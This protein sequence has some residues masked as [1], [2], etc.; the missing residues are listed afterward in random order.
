MLRISASRTAS[1]AVTVGE[2]DELAVA[3]LA[4]NQ[5][6]DPGRELAEQQIAFPVTR[7]RTVGNLG[8]ALGDHHLVRD[9]ALPLMLGAL[10]RRAA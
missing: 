1:S 10:L 6:R 5:R 7:D 8:R 3:G 4:L 2:R 9:L